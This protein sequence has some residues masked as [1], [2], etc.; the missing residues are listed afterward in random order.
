MAEYMGYAHYCHYLHN[1]LNLIVP[2]GTLE[3]FAPLESWMPGVP[4][5]TV[6]ICVGVIPRSIARSLQSSKSATLASNF[7]VSNMLLLFTSRYSSPTQ[8]QTK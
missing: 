8:I 4:F 5:T 6:V 2:N 1:V 3:A 7:F